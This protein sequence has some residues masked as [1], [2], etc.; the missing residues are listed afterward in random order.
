MSR[1]SEWRIE[2]EKQGLSKHDIL[3]A[4]SKEYRRS[5]PGKVKEYNQSDMVKNRSISRHMRVRYGLTRE[6]YDAMIEEQGNKCRICGVE[7]GDRHTIHIDHSH[8]TGKVR[9]LLCCN[10]NK[11]LGNVKDS[12][13]ILQGMIKYLS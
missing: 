10:C 12:I 8:T 5:N 13:D 11:A 4:Y 1:K 2:L 6:Q 3:V 7:F 9:G